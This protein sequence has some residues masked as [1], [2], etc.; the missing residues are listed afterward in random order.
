MMNVRNLCLA[1]LALTL[2]AC[3]GGSRAPAEGD[4]A[5]GAAEGA[6]VT[7]V[8]YASPTCPH[9]ALWQQNTWPAFKAAYVDTNKVRYVFRELPTPPTDIAAAGFLLAR[10]AGPDRYFDVIHAIMDSQSE[11]RTGTNP[12]DS[13]IR[14][15]GGVG[16]DQA[17]FTACVTDP[18]AIAALETRVKAATDA[19]VINTPTFLVN[20]K[21]VTSPGGEGTVMADLAPAI[22]AEL[23]K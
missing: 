4:M 18:K 3:G 20:G 10:C 16:I 21:R 13:L 8:E 6:K 19:G 14:I 23:A 15:A 17:A 12:R 2:S 7:V 11:W 5:M 1:F 9:C 22:D